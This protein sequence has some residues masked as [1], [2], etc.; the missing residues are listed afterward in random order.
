MEVRIKNKNK[1]YEFDLRNI[2]QFLGMNFRAKKFI[3]DSIVKHFS[4]YKYKEYEE[5][6]I[7]NVTIDGEV[8]GRKEYSVIYVRD[9]S[10]LIDYLRFGK[11]SMLQD[12]IKKMIEGISCQMEM[13]VIDGALTEIYKNIN[14]KLKKVAS[15]IQ[16]DYEYEKI[17]DM[18]STSEVETS[19]GEDIEKLSNFELLIS[20]INIV[21]KL[22]EDKN[23]KYMF[24]V[25][26]IDHIITRVEYNDVIIKMRTITTSIYS[27]FTISTNDYVAVADDL[28][29][30]IVVM[31]NVFFKVPEM[32]EMN[33]FVEDNYPLNKEFEKEELC[34]ILK[35]ILN[36]VGIDNYKMDYKDIIVRKMINNSLCIND[37]YDFDVKN[38]EIACINS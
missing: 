2:N 13:N 26:N 27:I 14:D 23:E 34:S 38:G 22:N 7:E 35:R 25:E 11:L 6:Y 9:R 17:L 5:E 36:E 15:N 20:L 29:D 31:N 16:I 37:F 18:V 1:H 21:K 3:V 8:R 28:M 10:S 12:L 33:K 4:S 19:D 32:D 30:G 24:I